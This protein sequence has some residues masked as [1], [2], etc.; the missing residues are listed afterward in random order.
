MTGFAIA[1]MATRH[2]RTTTTT[3]GTGQTLG[4]LFGLSERRRDD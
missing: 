3:A 2:A 1:Q 4:L